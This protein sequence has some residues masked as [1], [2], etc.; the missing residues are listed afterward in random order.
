MVLQIIS[1][2]FLQEIFQR[3][4]RTLRVQAENAECSKSTEKKYLKFILNKFKILQS[5]LE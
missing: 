5:I 2:F 4:V 1:L 3:W